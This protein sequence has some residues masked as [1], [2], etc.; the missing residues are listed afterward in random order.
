MVKTMASQFDPSPPPP[1]VWD[2]LI[3]ALEA[4]RG[5]APQD[6]PA[7]PDAPHA[8]L[9]FDL[10]APVP[11]AYVPQCLRCGDREGHEVLD[12]R[13]YASWSDCG[14]VAERRRAELWASVG[15]PRSL[16]PC[17]LSALAGN[18]W[19]PFR[20]DVG[21]GGDPQRV[22]AL[23]VVRVMLRAL[24]DGQQ[25]A[26]ALLHGAPGRGK[27][28]L[29][30][31]LCSGCTLP[32]IAPNLRRIA[33]AHAARLSRR[34]VAGLA[35]GVARYVSCTTLAAEAH[36]ALDDGSM[37]ALRD[38]LCAVPVLALD[39]VGAMKPG[40]W[41]AD[42]VGAVLHQRH[43]HGLTTV[44]ATNYTPT[45]AGPASLAERVTPHILSRLRAL[46]AVALG[47]DDMRAERPPTPAQGPDSCAAGVG[48]RGGDETGAY[49]ARGAARRHGGV[50]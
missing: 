29:L 4:R 19:R 48:T 20:V 14:C 34:G 50:L 22:A 7:H 47:G 32:A 11:V 12:A 18:E 39:E 8:V 17:S 9:A 25:P 28:H 31:A 38:T 5:E 13:G 36:G 23:E 46:P 26:G 6:P 33:A 43:E 42:L 45:G 15:L 37:G 21:D 44:A 30:A 2:G 27:S 49:G 24:R 1:S 16:A 10:S 35:L 40:S 3:E 41:L